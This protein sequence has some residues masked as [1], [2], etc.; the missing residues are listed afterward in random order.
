MIKK[1]KLGNIRKEIDSLDEEVLNL[2]NKRSSL[3]IE[4]GKEKQDEDIYKPDRE[5]S[6]FKR[7]K[8]INKGPLND[9][10]VRNIY[11]EI[12]SSCRAN[13][14]KIEV[15]F[16][17]PEGTY[18]D[19]AVKGNFGSSIEKKPA[20]TIEGVFKAVLTKQSDYGI[21][22]IENSSEGQVNETLDCLSNYDLNI[23]GEIEMVIHHS[24]MGLNRSLP[25]EGFEIHAHEQTFAQCKHWLDSYCPSV[26]RV[27]VASNSQAAKNSKN[28]S[29]ILAIAGSLAADRYGL[30][31][32]KENIEDYPDNTTRFITIGLQDVSISGKDKTSII[33][34]TKNESGSLYRILKP[35]NDNGINLTHITYRPSRVDKW[36]YSFFLD[37]EGH[38][39]EKNVKS[40][41]EQLKQASLE[42]KVLGSYPKAQI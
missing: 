32:I 1:N 13:E 21:V 6:I 8:E 14:K 27:A 40:L 37:L 22:P 38:K 19:S 25:R 30:E 31:I 18:S 26:K 11:R 4:A 36:N 33:V 5:A 20:E 42:I 34:T 7:L 39:D 28:E 17:G 23:C 9:E 2:L 29:K 3:A 10:H 35:I 16:L 41:L 24:L 15:A 12:I